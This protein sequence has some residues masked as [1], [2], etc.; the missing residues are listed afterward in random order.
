MTKTFFDQKSFNYVV[1]SFDDRL[2][3]P[4]GKVTRGVAVA[5]PLTWDDIAALGQGLKRACALALEDATAAGKCQGMKVEMVAFDDRSD[6]REAVSVANRIVSDPSIVAVVGH[7]NSGCSIPASQ[8]YARAHL[9]MIS[10]AAS[11]PKLTLQQLE[12]D[13]KYP[14]SIFR[15]NTTDDVQGPFAADYAL[16]TLK[17]RRASIIHDKTAYGQGVAEEFKKRF[18]AMGGQV[19]S[20]DGIN[21]A[22]KDF[23]ALLTRIHDEK[24]QIIY[25]GGDYAGGGLVVR[26]ARDV[27]ITSPVILSEANYDPEYLRVAGPAAE[28]TYITFLGAPADL[29]PSAQAFVK[30]YEARYP[31]DELKAYDH[32]GYEAMS[33]ILDLIHDVGPDREKILAALP[34]IKHEGVLGVTQFDEKGDTLNKTIT[35]FEVKDGKF[36]PLK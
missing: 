36:V 10:P 1:G 29:L 16:K 9:P 3:G 15:V 26:Q 30:R 35:I 27:G 13:W 24:A 34:K 19:V 8:V 20:F 25:W 22:D 4:E 33:I 5:L 21:V 23:N 32:W 28:G 7:F 2:R 14:R 11:N 6:P 18:E 31:N 17:L 12:P